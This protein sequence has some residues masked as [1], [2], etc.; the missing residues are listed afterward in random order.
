M[1]KLTSIILGM[2][3]IIGLGVLKVDASF[4]QPKETCEIIEVKQSEE[5]QET[6]NIIEKNK[7]YLEEIKSEFQ[8][9]IKYNTKEEAI[10][11]YS[12]DITLY[13][14]VIQIF[15]IY[16]N[17]EKANQLASVIFNR[18]IS[19]EFP[20]TIKEVIYQKGQFYNEKDQILLESIPTLKAYDIVEKA[21]LQENVEGGIYEGV[22]INKLKINPNLEKHELN[23]LNIE[24]KK[25]EEVHI[26]EKPLKSTPAKSPNMLGDTYVINLPQVNLLLKEL[27][28]KYNTKEEAMENYSEELVL[29]AKIVH[30]EACYEGLRGMSGVA[31][32]IY[33]RLRS[34]KFPNTI[35]EVI[36]QKGQFYDKEDG[37]VPHAVPNLQAYDA[38]ELVLKGYNASGGG[39]FYCNPDLVKDQAAMK[40]F[41]LQEI[42]GAYKNVVYYTNS[43]LEEM[44]EYE[45]SHTNYMNSIM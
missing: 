41:N 4:E 11:T 1:K 2:V 8:R 40:W 13:A 7:T 19:D 45:K 26:V 32:I 33:N 12:E 34:D 35:K 23:I 30:L 43:Y 39:F 31:S 37:R 24:E 14:K 44:P 27:K 36:Y 38:I 28:T 15:L 21:I 10:N 5:I 6:M 20:N 9:E 22:Y 18:L 42:T 25:I 16:S 3:I 29:Y 17:E